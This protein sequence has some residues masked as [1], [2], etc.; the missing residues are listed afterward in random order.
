MGAEAPVSALVWLSA[1]LL[2]LAIMSCCHSG[3]PRGSFTVTVH[4]AQAKHRVVIGGK[5]ARA[6]DD[7]MWG[8]GTARRVTSCSGTSNPPGN[9]PG[10]L[11]G[12][13]AKAATCFNL[14][15]PCRFLSAIIMSSTTAETMTPPG[16]EKPPAPL[17][18]D[19]PVRALGRAATAQPFTGLTKEFN[20]NLEAV[21]VDIGE[22][23]PRKL[24]RARPSGKPYLPGQPRIRLAQTQDPYKQDS[25]PD[26]DPLHEYL[27]KCHTTGPLD[28][29]LPLMRYIFVQTPSYKHVM[30]LHH[31]KTHA[32]EIKV[33][34]HPGLHLVWFYEIVFIKPIPAYFYCKAFWEYLEN[35]DKDLHKACL[36]FMRSYYMLIQYSIDY[37]EACKLNLIPTKDG[38]AAGERPTYEEWC[39]FIEPFAR[40][41]D[42]HVSRRYHY[43]ELR[44]T[45]LNRAAFLFKGN[46]AYFHIYPQWGSFL[47]HTLAPIITIFAVCSIVLNAM[48]VSLAAMEVGNEVDTETLSRGWLQFLDASLWFPVVVM[49]SIAAVLGV[50]V[51]GMGVMGIRDFWRGNQVRR[52]RKSG[53]YDS[54][55]RTHGMVW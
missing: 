19:E 50:A 14:R 1:L 34:E 48:Q 26:R 39:E 21:P 2:R 54:G 6:K 11:C 45:R 41:G 15:I 31:Q 49:L 3:S 46:L 23:E 24:L 17:Q 51:I 33:A 44:L 28:A 18:S 40:V 53:D 38:T 12:A 25:S 43:G 13:G 35:V 9:W 27:E 16:Q 22:K 55:N 5:R 32:R 47:E 37:D 4:G 42:K 52:K 36:G 10:W 20:Q 7:E 29:L 8:R 30:P